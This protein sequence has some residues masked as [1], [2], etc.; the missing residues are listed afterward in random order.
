M[1]QSRSRPGFEVTAKK[2]SM[3]TAWWSDK[4]ITRNSSF[5]KPVQAEIE[6]GNV[7]MGD[8]DEPEEMIVHEPG[9][10]LNEDAPPVVEKRVIPPRERK[11]HP[12]YGDYEVKMPG[13]KK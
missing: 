3:V 7:E 10:E 11:M 13:K 2:G 1:T 12:K 4:N 8:I 6:K 9:L 5:F